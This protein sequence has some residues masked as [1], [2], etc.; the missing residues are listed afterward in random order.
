M[1]SSFLMEPSMSIMF[2][3]CPSPA[4]SFTSRT[5]PRGSFSSWSSLFWRYCWVSPTRTLSSSGT[6]TPE[7]ADIGTI[8][9]SDLK[10]FTR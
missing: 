8:A 5:I 10:S 3:V 9:I 7:R 6:P 1:L 4:S 2:A